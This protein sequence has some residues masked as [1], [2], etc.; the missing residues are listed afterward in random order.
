MSSNLTIFVTVLSILSCC[1]DAPPASVFDPASCDAEPSTAVIAVSGLAGRS[2]AIEGAR[3]SHYNGSY[4]TSAEAI[5]D[6]RF[7]GPVSEFANTTTVGPIELWE[8]KPNDFGAVAFVD[9]RAVEVVFAGSVIW[10]G[11]GAQITQY[12]DRVVP[13]S[14]SPAPIAEIAKIANRYW[15]NEALIDE[16]IKLALRSE[17]AY[18]YAACDN[19]TALFY[20]YTPSVGSA[21][22]VSARALLIIA[23]HRALARL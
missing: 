18:S 4:Q 11:V 5:S 15:T 13:L 14:T 10:T 8:A 1:G 17:I 16:A 12:T 22:E 7:P 6:L 9:A 19:L 23:G 2:L 3:I 21:D 20:V